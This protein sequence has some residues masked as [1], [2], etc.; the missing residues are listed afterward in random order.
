MPVSPFAPKMLPVLPQVPG[1]AMAAEAT[2]LKVSRGGKAARDMLLVRLPEGTR[3]AGRFT[4][5][6]TAA[7][8][9]RWCRDVVGRGRARAL[10]VNA[11]NANAFTGARGEAD[12]VRTAE[13]V[14]AAMG[15]AAEEVIIASTGVIGEPLPMEKMLA[16]IATCAA[17]LSEATPWLHAA[18]AIGTTDTYP[19]LCCETWERG[20]AFG[21]AKGS[22]MIAP[23]LATML[24]FLWV[25][26]LEEGSGFEKSLAEACAT[27]FEA[28]TVD[29][30]TSTNDSVVAF[31]LPSGG[32]AMSTG[33]AAAH[34]AL[35]AACANLALQVV[36]DGEGIT[37][38]ITVDV[39]GAASQADAKR[40]A[41]AIAN[42][43]L[44]K[45]A[46]AGEDANWGRVVMAI[47]KSGA[48]VDP[49][50]LSITFGSE[51]VASGGARDPDYS[52][53]R[54]AAYLK[55]PNIDI[56]VDLGL[57]QGA[58]VA[59]TCDLTHEYIRINADY[60]S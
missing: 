43:P 3:V 57:G 41:F 8:P 14:A 54:A 51:R 5:S 52:E 44:V 18:E 17:N 36:A 48:R 15:C 1:L 60:R 23:D 35:A 2:G 16:G 12:V 7:A 34:A 9:V 30:D 39:K 46:I 13:T 26:G 42:S 24:A 55:T 37:K 38:L 33:E 21:I 20:H 59:R 45:T 4:T 25:T 6:Q 40:L 53:A 10:L 29:G 58:F 56:H 28:I 31:A 49:A 22:G 50:A 11:G 32:G 19:K 27:S 47:G